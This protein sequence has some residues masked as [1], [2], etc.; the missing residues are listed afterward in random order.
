MGTIIILL[1][2]GFW[3]G[4]TYYLEHKN[5]TICYSDTKFAAILVTCVAVLTLFIA[6]T[7]IYYE[8]VKD[9][10]NLYVIDEKIE[11]YETRTNQLTEDLK[12]KYKNHEKS[13][14]S[15]IGS[16]NLSLLL[17]KYPELRASETFIEYS[18]QIRRLNNDKYRMELNKINLQRDISTRLRY[19]IIMNWILPTE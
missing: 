15:D 11:V 9:I 8:Q 7:T 19:P 1:L 12:T 14:F 5:S 16:D 3:I 17:V 10:E 13:I 6:H 18:T 4:L 2:C